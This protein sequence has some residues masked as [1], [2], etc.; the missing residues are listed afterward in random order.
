MVIL[1]QGVCNMRKPKVGPKKS[2]LKQEIVGMSWERIS[3]DIMGLLPKSNS[4]NLYIS[5]IGD[6]FTKWTESYALK[7]HTGQTIADVLVNQWICRFGVPQRIHT[8]QGRDL[9]S[10]LIHEMCQLLGI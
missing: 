5:V 6:Y 9:E 10:N 7:D 1:L 3:M 8:D 4:G 2:P